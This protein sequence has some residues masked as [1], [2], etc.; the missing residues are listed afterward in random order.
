[1]T[2]LYRLLSVERLILCFLVISFSVYRSHSSRD[3]R[4]VIAL[5]IGAMTVELSRVEIIE[6]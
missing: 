6:S 1:M 3:S 5:S 2:R 4:P